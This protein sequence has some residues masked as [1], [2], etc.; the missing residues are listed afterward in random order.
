ML[1]KAL[2]RLILQMNQRAQGDHIW[3]NSTTLA[4][5]LKM[6]IYL[7]LIWFWAK[8]STHFGTICMKLG[9]FSLLKMAK[10]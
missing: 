6:A 5:N 7:R 3:R 10:Y 2:S 4:N 1:V 9:A 8:F